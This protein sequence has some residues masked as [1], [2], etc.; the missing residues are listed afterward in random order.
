VGEA[1][2]LR[3]PCRGGPWC[4]GASHAWD[5]TVLAADSIN[6]QSGDDLAQGIPPNKNSCGMRLMDIDTGTFKDEVAYSQVPRAEGRPIVGAAKH[7][8]RF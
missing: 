5:C 4:I 6:F 8:Q 1:K 3:M 2:G 7:T